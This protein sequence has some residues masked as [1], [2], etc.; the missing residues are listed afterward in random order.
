M[1]H[2]RDQ[3]ETSS[4][5]NKVAKVTLAFWLMKICAT[6]V[7]ETAGDLRSMTLGIGYAVSS[8]ILI[9]F[10]LITLVAQLKSDR[11]HPFLYWAVI[12]ATSTAGTTISD[13]VD[14]TPPVQGRSA[15]QPH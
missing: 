8:G 1:G 3:H 15:V 7:G 4:A 10:F 5:T 12:L 14:R 11:F 9:G 13:Y 6:T 2:V